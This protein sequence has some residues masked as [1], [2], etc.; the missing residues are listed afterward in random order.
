MMLTIQNGEDVET[1]RRYA[2]TTAHLLT[3]HDDERSQG[4][5]AVTRDR[6][7][8]DEADGIVASLP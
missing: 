8:F 6:E 4:S 7:E 5:T 2:L 1:G 3:D